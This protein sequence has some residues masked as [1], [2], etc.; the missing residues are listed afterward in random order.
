VFKTSMIHCLF[1]LA[2]VG[3][4]YAQ[5]AEKTFPETWAAFEKLSQKEMQS[6]PD[7]KWSMT[8]VPTANDLKGKNEVELILLRNSIYAQTGFHFTQPAM[9]HYFATRSWYTPAKEDVMPLTD[10]AREAA[11]AFLQAQASHR[12]VAEADGFDRDA[13]EV[14]YMGFCTYPTR[15]Q[16]VGG[17]IVFEAGGKARVFHSIGS[18]ESAQGVNAYQSNLPSSATSHSRM[19]DAKWHLANHKV[20]V[21]IDAAA[22]PAERDEE[23]GKIIPGTH[24]FPPGARTVLDT[25]NMNG[26]KNRQCEMKM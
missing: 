2:F 4:A 15:W 21:D 8:N 23:T 13:Y 18:S 9:A 25:Q 22:I 17:M 26:L 1:V 3:G 10:T 24:V 19:I 11:H 12:G 7:A 14:F 5:A 6:L 16:K 20:I